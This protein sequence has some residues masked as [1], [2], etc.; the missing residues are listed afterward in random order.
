MKVVPPRKMNRIEMEAKEDGANEN[1]FME[2]AGSG[3]ALVVQEFVERYN[4][5]RNLAVLT[6]KGNNA[7][8]AYVAAVHL[9]HLDYTL[10]VYQYPSLSLSNEMTQRNAARFAAEG[11]EIVEISDASEIEFPD[12]GLILDGIFGTGF[13]RHVEEPFLS[14]I[15]AANDSGLMIISIDIPS[16]LNGATGEVFPKS[17]KAT[18]TAFLGLPKTGFFLKDGWDM[19]G[20]LRYVDFGLPPEYI[21]E[22]DADFI[23]LTPEIV[24]PML[25]KVNRTRHKYE[26][27]LTVGLAGS[28][29]MPGAALL[30]SAA[31]LRSGTGMM[32]LLYPETMR[33]ELGSV[34][35]EL[36]K[37]GYKYSDTDPII[38]LLNKASASFIGPGLGKSPEAKELLQIVLKEIRRLCVIDA[39]ALTL[40]AENGF[41][42]PS[43]AI[44]TPHKGELERLLRRDIPR[45]LTLEFLSSCQSW[46]EEQKITLVLKGAPTFIF[47]PGE[48]IHVSGTGDPGMATAGTGDILTGLIAGLLSQHILPHDAARLGVFLHGLAGEHAA[49]EKTSYCMIAEDL[50][51][52]FPAAFA[53][54]GA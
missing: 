7:G 20:T 11:G 1:E 49:Q 21:E 53:F 34:P 12:Q 40:I 28:P 30:A 23:M 4:I 8:D 18:E 3:I 6:G 25:P 22:V 16:G 50:L 54:E 43:G 48:L 2:E 29:G 33:E 27:G 51:D 38:E 17:I 35:L 52:Y 41:D 13:D 36:V 46:V 39:D 14:I 9:L 5:P 10:T 24:I 37:V 19:V 45:E 31:A 32:K 15:Q 42:I 44:I 47:H 26:A